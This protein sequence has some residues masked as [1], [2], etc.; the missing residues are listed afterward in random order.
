MLPQQPLDM[1][2]HWAPNF[3]IIAFL[4]V[5]S[6]IVFAWMYSAY[7]APEEAQSTPTE[8]IPTV[9]PVDSDT[10]FLPSPAAINSS[11]RHTVPSK[12]TSGAPSMRWARSGVTRAQAARW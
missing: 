5:M 7:F 4:V 3:A 8:V 12:N 2:N 11:S 1:P 10:L 6:A 9:T